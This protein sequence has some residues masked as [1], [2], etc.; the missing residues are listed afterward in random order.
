MSPDHYGVVRDGFWILLQSPFFGK[1]K[2]QGGPK[3]RPPP[4]LFCLYYCSICLD[5]Q[6]TYPVN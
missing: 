3:N 6:I 2:I 1:I 4:T 5:A